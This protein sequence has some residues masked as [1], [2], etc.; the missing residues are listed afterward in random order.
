M[1]A[2]PK[3]R[4]GFRCTSILASFFFSE[5]PIS[6]AVSNFGFY[7]SGTNVCFIEKKMLYCRSGLTSSEAA[8]SAVVIY[9]GLTWSCRE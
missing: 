6:V 2:F 3:I 5:P 4:H 8:L 9:Y 7:L 1:S